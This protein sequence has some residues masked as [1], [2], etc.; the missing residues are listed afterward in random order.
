MSEILKDEQWVCKIKGGKEILGRRD[1][2]VQ[3]CLCEWAWYCGK[4]GCF[5]QVKNLEWYI[6][7]Q[8]RTEKKIE[9]TK[10]VAGLAG[11]TK[12]FGASTLTSGMIMEFFR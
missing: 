11:H 3:K 7:F 12:H 8:K 6:L 2:T 4:Q 9:V 10:M 5:E 1:S